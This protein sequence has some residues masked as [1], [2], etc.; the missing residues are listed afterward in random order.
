MDDF[1]S[2]PGIEKTSPNWPKQYWDVFYLCWETVPDG[3]LMFLYILWAETLSLFLLVYLF[4]AVAWWIALEDRDSA[5]LQSQQQA[6]LVCSI[7]NNNGSFMT[8]EQACLLP[9]ITWDYC[10]GSLSSGFLSCD[11]TH[12]ESR[13]HLTS[14]TSSWRS[15]GPREPEHMLI[16]W[17]PLSL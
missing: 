3:F 17:L 5:S 14:F 8:K 12:C 15:R 6:Y 9:I 16:L 1:G 4:K 13:Y 7:I 2:W 10:S 11:T